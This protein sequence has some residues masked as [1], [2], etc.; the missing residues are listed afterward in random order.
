MNIIL[1]TDSY[2]ASHYLQYPPKTEFVGSYIEARKAPPG[3]EIVHFGLQV[4]LKSNPLKITWDDVHEAQL[5]FQEHGDPFNMDGWEYIMNIHEG[6]LPVMIQSLPEGT[7]I[8]PGTC[9][10]QIVNTDPK[11]PWLTSYLETA[12]LRA[13]WYP[14]TVATISREIKKVIAAYMKLTSDSLDGLDFKLHDFGARG[15]SSEESAAIG[16]L[17]HLVNFKGGDT[18]SALR[19]ARRY[20]NATTAVGFS[21]PAA[22][23]S[24]IT[25][26]GK[27]HE[28]DA[29]SNMIDQFSGKDRIFAVV[30]DSYDIYNA[31]DNIWGK[32]LHERVV[33]SGGT[34]VIRPDSGEPTKVI[35]QILRS[36][37]NSFGYRINKKHYKVLPPYLRIIQGDGVD[38]D[39]IRD[40]LTDMKADGWSAD[41]IAFGMGGALLQK[42]NR[43]TFSYAMK[44]NTIK[45]DGAWRDVYKQP[46]T[47]KG[48]TSK[49]G[50]QAVVMR[51]GRMQTV[52][53]EDIAYPEWDLLRNV[54]EDGHL[55]VDD[56]FE[57]I[58]KRASIESKVDCSYATG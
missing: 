48:K 27:E 21:I 10:L 51:E 58:R 36:L 34:L 40:I 42:L 19:Y 2:K 32:K 52:R 47:D 14:S 28:V 49:R 26:W 25:A 41:N 50:W 31:V 11:V 7:V 22:E 12:L 4:F 37:G 35:R 45:V 5:N 55:I 54:Y 20:Y 3:V 57:T 29:Y 15:V 56:D 16:G 44:A 8:P 1:N 30:S 6:R 33:N 43:D 17:A 23:H 38:I 46:V 9:Q 24:T 13:I 18:M 39:S 53:V